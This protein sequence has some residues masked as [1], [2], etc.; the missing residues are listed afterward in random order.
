MA[1]SLQ[2]AAHVILSK[3]SVLAFPVNVP[4]RLSCLVAPEEGE[5][6]P[7]LRIAWNHRWEHDKGPEDFFDALK[8][9]HAAG[10]RFQVAVLGTSHA[11][12]NAFPTRRLRVSFLVWV[13]PGFPWLSLA[14][15]G[16][17]SSGERFQHA[18]DC[19]ETAQEWLSR[20]D[21]IL[22]WGY[23]PSREDVRTASCC[24]QV[25]AMS[26]GGMLDVVPHVTPCKLWWLYHT[27]VLQDFGVL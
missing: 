16:F 1:W 22:H 18:P 24:V 4:A 10:L 9:L 14:W 17:L 6:A 15:C 12:S 26:D 23:A 25:A 20:A 8:S 11:C 5:G 19:F 21:A 3:S 13:F 27:T 2:G 7:P